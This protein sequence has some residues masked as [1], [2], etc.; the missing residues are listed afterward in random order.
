MKK[1]VLI[2]IFTVVFPVLCFSQYTIS[3]KIIA[4]EDSSPLSGAH[5]SLVN[6]Y[7]RTASDYQGN[8]KIT[9]INEG[10]YTI[11]VSYIGYETKE[12]TITVNSDITLNFA[13]SFKPIV[14][15][16]VIISAVKAS[17][18]SPT[19][20]A[21]VDEE[22]IEKINL[23][24]DLPYL[25][26]TTP[27]VVVTSDAG[28]GIGYTGIRIR[29]TDIT[30]INV[31]ING[32]PLNDPE[33]HLVYW[34]D[35]PDISS[36]IDNIQIQRG[37][38]TSTNG[39]AAFGASINIQTTEL[40]PDPYA[41]INSSAGSFNTFKNNVSFGTGLIKGR[42]SFSGRLSKISSDGYI[43]RATSDLKS[44]YVSGGYYGENSMLKAVIFSGKEK[45]YQ[46]WYGVPKD[47][48][49]T[50]RTYNPYT[51][52]DQ[53]DNYWQ[54]H[55]QLHYTKQFNKH[56]Y[57]NTSLFLITGKGYYEEYEE[58]QM[59]IN[60]D[61]PDI[62]IGDTTISSTNLIRQRWLDNNFYGVTY[63]LKYNKRKIKTILGGAWN[64]YDGDHFGEIIWAQYASNIQKD[65]RWYE[66]TGNKT[67]FNV[68]SKTNYQLSKSFNLYIDLQYRRIKYDLDGI[69]YNLRDISNDVKFDFFNP[70][71]GIYYNINNNQ[72]LYFSFA[73]S[74]REPSR[75]NY[76]D[77]DTGYTPQPERLYDYELG[78]KLNRPNFSLET[79][80]YFM[81]YKDQLVLTGEINDYGAPIMTNVPKSYRAGI[82]MLAGIQIFD[83]L[84]WDMNL[85]LS[86]NKIK[87]F[88]DHIDMYDSTWTFTD[89]KTED[90]ITTDL[91][92]SPDIVA[93]SNITYEPLKG[94]DI[95]FISKYVSRQY[96]DNTSC[97]ERS[98]D[99]YFVNN[100]VINYII[101]TGFIKELGLHFMVNNIFNEKYETYAWVY[102]YYLDG[103]YHESNGYFPQA[104]I[105][106]MGGI[107]LKF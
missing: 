23:G 33:S 32:I 99:P 21:D 77:A 63:S 52:E 25:I 51:Y 45:T 94:L 53:T 18:G 83:D 79:N 20:F 30:R 104:G 13:L 47:S 26:E 97:K 19:T 24:Q 12:K 15:D 4:V 68:Y 14:E 105:N 92:F 58:N 57:L 69:H 5:V 48:L 88:V 43:D 73:V 27:S 61:L 80:I 84:K 66:N 60:Y 50:N 72:S 64:K 76:R 38:G 1:I 37:V 100:L 49:E 6:T 89:Q 22:E 41:E 101:E 9:N 96:I 42:W 98:L 91:S 11:K 46:A 40:Q 36:S 62:I 87:D 90:L 39:A 67:D 10:E 106:F 54:D 35:L 8:Y 2:L 93:G 16:E 17:E 71:A 55:Y 31:T 59:F 56:L 65:Y 103:K 29:G 95:S 34:V 74:N 78:Y 102:K 75:L 44:F 3:G 70:K 7:K 107:S 86:R 28:A 85:S 81:D 82:E